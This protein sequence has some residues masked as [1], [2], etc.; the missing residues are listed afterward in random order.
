MKEGERADAFGWG[1]EGERMRIPLD[2]GLEV[3]DLSRWLG[4]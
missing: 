2:A 1:E 4:E 3:L